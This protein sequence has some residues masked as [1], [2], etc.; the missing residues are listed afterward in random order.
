MKVGHVGRV[1]V[2]ILPR[3][4]PGKRAGNVADRGRL[5]PLRARPRA[6]DKTLGKSMTIQR[7]FKSQFTIWKTVSSLN[8]CFTKSILNMLINYTVL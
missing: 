3:D 1:A 2:N 5:P 6:F 7:K 4:M 8:R